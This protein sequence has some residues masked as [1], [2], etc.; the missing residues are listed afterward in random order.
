MRA[1][2]AAGLMGIALLC[3]CVTV[4]EF[5]ALE[6]EVAQLKRGGAPASDDSASRVADLGEEVARLREEVAQLRG[7]VEE[8]TFRAEEALQ[9]ARDSGSAPVSPS[10]PERAQG[11]APG[12]PAPT[13]AG[14]APSM[15]LTEEVGAYDEAFRLY[16]VRDYEGAIDRFQAFLQNYPTSEYADNALFWL[17]ECH[18]KLGDYEQAVLKFH[19]VV[20]R[21]PTG[22]KV[23]DSL[24]RQG[25]ALLELGKQ[26]ARQATYQP[27]A[28]QVF[29]R[30]LDDYPDSERVAETRRQVEINCK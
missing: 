2:P 14:A 19:D 24:Y 22:N 25:V 20:E 3:G 1:T 15:P 10:V 29:Q 9:A 26:T 7:A 27:A 28:C 21:F 30:L 18:F 16:R 4:P 12:P 17:G 11:A 8:A 13:G 6:R 23:P 5:R